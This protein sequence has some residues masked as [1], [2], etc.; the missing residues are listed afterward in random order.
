MVGSIPDFCSAA[1]ILSVG[2]SVDLAHPFGIISNFRVYGAKIPE[3]ILSTPFAPFNE[4]PDD[5]TVSNKTFES[6]EH[7]PKVAEAEVSLPRRPM[8]LEQ[9][10][11]D[12]ARERALWMDLFTALDTDADG[13][14][15]ENEFGKALSH[16]NIN[17]SDEMITKLYN[18]VAKDS[19]KGVD[20][21]DFAFWLRPKDEARPSKDPAW[22]YLPE[23]HIASLLGKDTSGV[24]MALI[25][26]TRRGVQEVSYWSCSA[27][28]NLAMLRH[29]RVKIICHGGIDALLGP[30]NSQNPALAVEAARALVMLR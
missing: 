10:R 11:L 25:G 29:N 23:T 13:F 22:A 28:G 21:H 5:I 1:P 6:R 27:L 9:R 8:S 2:N 18:K 3:Y 30:C 20:L 16:V 19:Q 12:D 15:L 4:A 26:A 7:A 17:F 24:V 14:L